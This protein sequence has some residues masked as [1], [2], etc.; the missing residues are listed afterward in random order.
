M[1]HFVGSYNLGVPFPVLYGGKGERASKLLSDDNDEKS[2]WDLSKH[3]LKYLGFFLAT[4]FL[5]NSNDPKPHIVPCQR[6]TKPQSVTKSEIG[7]TPFC[8]QVRDRQKPIL[9]NRTA[10]SERLQF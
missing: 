5:L 8:P 7:K 4:H 10:K 3:F 1:N 9:E 2:K 6:R